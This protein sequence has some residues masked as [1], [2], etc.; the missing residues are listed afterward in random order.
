MLSISYVQNFA[1]VHAEIIYLLIILGV[2]T[3]GEI[4][5]IIAGIFAHLGSI[6]LPG[7][8]LAVLV[9]G[10]TKSVFGYSLGY[11]LQK[12]HSDKNF[13]IRAEDKVSFF[14]PR[15]T[16]KS[17]IS[18][19][20]SRFLILGMYW[21]TLIYSGYKKVKLRTFIKAEISSLLS[22][23]AIMLS[24]GFFFSYTALSINRDI[25]NFIIVILVFFIMFLIIEKIITFFIELFEIGK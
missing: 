20:F 8:F 10:A 14:F 7:A 11:Y 6:S 22:W 19:F 23:T 2:F 13:L 3:E 12:K 15:F 5:V 18:I 21:F 4:M 17:F 24:V 9:G 1:A 16:E 25:R